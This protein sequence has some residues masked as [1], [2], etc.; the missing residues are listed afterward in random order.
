M[1]TKVHRIPTEEEIRQDLEKI[2]VSI[3]LIPA[4]GA[5]VAHMRTADQ[6][7]G[8]MLGILQAAVSEMKDDAAAR[9]LVFQVQK[10]CSLYL[11][12]GRFSESHVKP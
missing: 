12:E 1:P 11:A 7:F 10:A 6:R 8:H 2:N 4:A 5:M 9:D 3:H